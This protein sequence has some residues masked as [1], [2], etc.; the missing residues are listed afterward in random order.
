MLRFHERCLT[1]P[2]CSLATHMRMRGVV[3]IHERRQQMATD[4]AMR[5]TAVRHL[6]GGVVRAAGTEKWLSF[7]IQQ[8]ALSGSFAACL[9]KIQTGLDG[10][11]GIKVGD[12]F[13]KDAHDIVR[14]IFRPVRQN[15]LTCFIEPTNNARTT[16]VG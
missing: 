13:G 15:H 12:A 16:R 1:E 5:A 7:N 11:A 9:Q 8:F 6:R 4:A 2:V 10:F 14:C 3:A